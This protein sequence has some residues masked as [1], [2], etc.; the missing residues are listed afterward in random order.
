MIIS[1][2]KVNYSV[3][4]QTKKQSEEQYIK[5]KVKRNGEHEHKQQ[6]KQIRGEERKIIANEVKA[7]FN[8]SAKNFVD[9]FKGRNADNVPSAVVIR[10]ICSE[11]VN[12][13]IVSTC[14]LTNLLAASDMARNNIL[15]NGILIISNTNV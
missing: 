8:G 3:S 9:T 4:L 12:Q 11:V 14:W 1:D 7:N 6:S 2:C 13:N 5:F 15:L 10:K